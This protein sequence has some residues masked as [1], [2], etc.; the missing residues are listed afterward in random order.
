MN[1]DVVQKD[2]ALEN[3]F[4]TERLKELRL[5]SSAFKNKEEVTVTSK[6]LN[7]HYNYSQTIEFD[8]TAGFNFQ[9]HKEKVMLYHI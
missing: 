9:S 7:N 1:I 8:I 6:Y 3:T 5:L 4:I 2:R